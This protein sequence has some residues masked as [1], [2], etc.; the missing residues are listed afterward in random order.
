MTLPLDPYHQSSPSEIL[1][2]IPHRHADKIIFLL[3]VP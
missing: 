3:G 2:L 1:F